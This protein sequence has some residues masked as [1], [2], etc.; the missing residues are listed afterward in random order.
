MAE[1]TMELRELVERHYPLALDRYPIFDE[2]HRAVLN[3]KIIQHFWYRE[4]WQE[5]PDRFN[6]MLSRKM[7]E[8][9]PYYNQLYVSTLIEYDPLATEFIN[10]TTK[11]V[12]KT[13]EKT[14]AGYAARSEERRVGKECRSRWS[15]YH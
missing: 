9:M 2:N 6:R 14:E 5:T 7:N 4:I 8:I 1:Y 3:N 10:A 15:P 11:D 12:T 13:K